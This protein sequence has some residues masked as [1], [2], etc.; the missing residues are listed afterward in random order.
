M[1]PNLQTADILSADQTGD[2][3]SRA[4][5]F[6]KIDYRLG[7]LNRSQTGFLCETEELQK[8]GSRP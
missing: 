2:R 8:D 7:H 5:D 1:E 6:V 4:A 3:I